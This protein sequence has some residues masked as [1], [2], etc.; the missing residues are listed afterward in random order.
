[1]VV[2]ACY[3]YAPQ[4]RAPLAPLSAPLEAT[5]HI[6]RYMS[7]YT[8]QTLAFGLCSQALTDSCPLPVKDG[9]RTQP[10]KFR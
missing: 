4:V 8:R 9:Q 7:N 1:M 5:N 6:T 10:P 3:S 2:N